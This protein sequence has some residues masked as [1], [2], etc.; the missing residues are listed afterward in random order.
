MK[1]TFAIRI[2]GTDIFLAGDTGSWGPMQFRSKDI[3][4]NRLKTFTQRGS[5]DKEQKRLVSTLNTTAGNEWVTG[6][7]YYE[8]HTAEGSI[9]KTGNAMH[10]LFTNDNV[11]VKPVLEAID[12]EVVEIR[13][14]FEVAN[15]D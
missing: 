11:E 1:K 4:G 6:H 9:Q 13:M 7:G 5:A 15:A 2:T 3:I 12:V 14:T 10:F 8:V